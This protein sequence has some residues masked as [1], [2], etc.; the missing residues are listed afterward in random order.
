MKD[1]PV[2]P[3]LAARPVLLVNEAP[4]EAVDNVDRKEHRVA[5]EDPDAKETPDPLVAKENEERREITENADA[6]GQRGRL[7][8]KE[9]KARPVPKVNKEIPAPA[10]PKVNVVI[11]VIRDLPVAQVNAESQVFKDHPARKDNA[12]PKERKACPEELAQPVLKARREQMAL[13]VPL[14]FRDLPVNEENKVLVVSAD[15][16]APREPPVSAVPMEITD[17]TNHEDLSSI[18]L[19][20]WRNTSITS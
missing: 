8:R 16:K 7:V 6:M 5:L 20:L 13:L 17:E 4:M 12:V 18:V 2:P 3:A 11:P 10:V 1:H 15:Q 14:V 9:R 19:L